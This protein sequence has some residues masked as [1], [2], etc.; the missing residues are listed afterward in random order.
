MGLCSFTRVPRRSF[1]AGVRRIQMEGGGACFLA[2]PLKALADHVHAQRVDWHS[3]TPVI[4]S[5]RLEKESL[6]GLTAEMFDEVV[7]AHRS[8]GDR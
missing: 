6:A 5:L 3:A 2:T 1:L 4:E 7:V 8:G